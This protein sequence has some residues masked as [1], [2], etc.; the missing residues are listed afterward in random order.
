[1]SKRH[2]EETAIADEAKDAR[3]EAKRLKKKKAKEGRE[4]ANGEQG[5]VEKKRQKEENAD[6][7]VKQRKRKSKAPE[8][9]E[10][11][12]RKERKKAKKAAKALKA[13][14]SSAKQDK[15][16][17]E[18]AALTALAQSEIDDFVVKHRM[19]IEDSNNSSFR[20]IISFK[21]LPVDESQKAP[22]S[23][24]SAPTPIQAA[25]WPY[26]FAGRDVVGVAETGSGK[27][28]GFGVPCVRHICRIGDKENI[29]ACIVSPTR[30]LAL[31]IQ[32]QLSEIARPAGLKVTCIYGGTDKD[33]QRSTIQGSN[34]IVATPGRL[35]DYIQEGSIDLSH[36]DYLVLDE[37]DRMLDTGFEPEIRKIISS[38]SSEKRQTLMF[39]ATWPQSVR[40]LAETFMTNA[41]RVAVGD[42]SSGELRAN[43]R[44]VQK[45]H[46]MD[47]AEKQSR[48]IDTLKKY[49]SGPRKN[50]KILVFCLYKKEATRIEEFIRRRNFNVGGIHGDMTQH[51]RLESLEAFRAG[52]IPILVAT[53]VVARGL[54]IPAVKVVINFT[55]PLTVE[56]YV[57]RIGRTGRAG[58]DGLAI[59]FF[60]E[61]EKRLAGALVNVLKA[62]GQDVPAELIK[63]GGT[64]KK[65]EHSVY[66]AFYKDPS[67][68][69]KPT[70][71]TFD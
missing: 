54:D 49:T 67:E 68:M 19:T 70:M 3:R 6:G 41:V 30:E 13:A 44:I 29:K 23:T 42:N 26:L 62:A 40:G 50:D 12:E 24:F 46:V 20:P 60:T 7:D 9:Q 10:E 66:G 59:T 4:G 63:F 1:M 22:F 18:D 35:N 47:G 16:Y 43:N 36:V 21:Y 17:T 65:K 56:D 38:T 31:Q 8:D 15:P 71:I 39:T 27:T 55:F 37:A 2:R 14:E 51:R 48:L 25:V 61:A 57:H 45:V 11:N 28:L 53:D 52:R 58:Q 33:S 64:V 5:V 32:T 69:K 34:I